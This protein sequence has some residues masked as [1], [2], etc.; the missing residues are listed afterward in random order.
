[1]STERLQ[2]IL[3]QAGIASR[4]K[5]EELIKMGLVTING[6]VAKL[7]DKADLNQDAIKVEGKLLHKKTEALTYIAFYK[8]KGVISMFGDP[9]ERPNLSD[10]FTKL[11]T[12]VFP[13]GRLDFNSEGILLLTN[14][15][16]LVE[17]VQKSNEF[18][19]TY[20]VKLKGHITAEMLERLK[21]GAK[22][23]NK[24]IKP[25]TARIGD[26]YNKKSLIE[27]M[28][29]NNTNVDVKAYCE[30]KGFLVE[31]VTR[32]AFGHITLHGL[33]PGQYRIVPKSK[34]QA[35]VDQPELGVKSYEFKLQKVKEILPYDIRRTKED[36]TP[37][38]IKIGGKKPAA[39]GASDK[40]PLRRGLG[41][42]SKSASKPS[43]KSV[44]MP[45]F[46]KS[47]RSKPNS[48]RTGDRMIAKV[49]KR[50]SR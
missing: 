17:K 36:D 12:R 46:T 26:E 45:E 20:H 14:D 39:S 50:P 7:G 24:F 22:I 35:L 5:A 38:R 33:V 29:L 27:M 28:F 25:H 13:I 18:P 30:M 41:L 2:K 47:A 43:S 10:Y 32:T 6:K 49:K 37:K 31:K 8:P 16:D 40:K 3:A 34:I 21:R 42:D 23:G 4:R 15:G 48:N 44:F 19:R 1:M 9:E 11:K